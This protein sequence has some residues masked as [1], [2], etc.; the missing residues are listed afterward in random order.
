MGDR[1]A[2]RCRPV[3]EVP[4]ERV[5]AISSR[6]GRGKRNRVAGRG[7]RRRRRR[8]CGQVGYGHDDGGGGRL[9][10][11]V[12]DRDRGGVRAGRRVGMGDRRARARR[13]VSERPSVG[14]P[15]G[16]ASG[17]RDEREHAAWARRHAVH[18]RGGGWSG[19]DSD[20]SRGSRTRADAVRGGARGRFRARGGVGV[21]C[22]PARAGLS[23]AKIPGDRMGWRP[24]DRGARERNR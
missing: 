23:V 22:G 3:A 10:D 5:A 2:C 21:R 18:C 1:R 8:R 14:I 6:A 11:A 12:A 4:R 15:A 9:A 7:S 19:V 16:A 17:G 24:P 13:A 20:G